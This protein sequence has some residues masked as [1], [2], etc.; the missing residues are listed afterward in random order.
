M[1]TMSAVTWTGRDRDTQK[2]RKEERGSLGF[3]GGEGFVY[4]EALSKRA[5]VRPSLIKTRFYRQRKARLCAVAPTRPAT[6]QWRNSA[7][8][9]TRQEGP[10]P[11]AWKRGRLGKA[12]IRPRWALREVGGWESKDA[13]A[14]AAAAEELRAQDGEICR[15]S[16]SL[17]QRT[18]C[19]SPEG[20]VGSLVQRSQQAHLGV[21]REAKGTPSLQGRALPHTRH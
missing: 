17:L 5:A 14:A 7:P 18:E 21:P 2:F 15:P 9:R 12:G 1:C 19:S 8:A 3:G 20:R 16:I 10:A 13:A 11:A 4:P 6:P